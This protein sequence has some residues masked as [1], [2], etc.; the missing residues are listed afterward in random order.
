MRKAAQEGIPCQS[1]T[2][3]FYLEATDITLP[4]RLPDHFQGTVMI[5]A[6]LL[7]YSLYPYGKF[8]H[9]RPDAVVGGS[10]LVFHGSFEVPEVAAERAGARGWWLL[11]HNDGTDAIV[12]LTAAR[13]HA[14]D[15]ARVDSL[16][17]WARAMAARL[18]RKNR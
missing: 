6:G 8:F 16:L 11:N 9:R 14:L 10:V 12:E 15:P 17:A 7:D 13:K 4:P 1:L 5:G 3:P 18:S 2:G